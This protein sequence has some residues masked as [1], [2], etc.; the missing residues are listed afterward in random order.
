MKY[1]ISH[2]ET[3]NYDKSEKGDDS[4]SN[5]KISGKQPLISDKCEKNIHTTSKNHSWGNLKNKSWG[6]NP[7]KNKTKEKNANSSTNEHHTVDVAYD[8]SR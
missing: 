5:K 1:N 7:W 6:N 8:N 4:S 3:M 2:K